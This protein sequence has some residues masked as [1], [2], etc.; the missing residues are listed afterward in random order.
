MGKTPV[1]VCRIEAPCKINLHLGIQE[2]RPDG[3]HDLKSLFVCLALGDTLRFELAGEE[4]S[5]SIDLNW[6]IPGETIPLEKNLVFQAVSLFR[7]R[8]GFSRGLWIRVD[9]RIPPGAGLGGG[10]SDAASALLALNLLSGADIQAEELREMAALLGSDTP[11]F[12]SGGAAY[13]SGRGERIE[14]LKVPEGPWVL[15]VKPP[16]ASDTAF[17]YRLL[18]EARARTR[19]GKRPPDLSRE[20][21][22]RALGEKPD[23]WPFYNDFLPVFLD[24]FSW[25]TGEARARAG[26]YRSILE[27]L[28]A[29]GA[30]F[31]GLSGSGSCC[32]GIFTTKGRVEEAK[33]AFFTGQNYARLT[34]FLAHRA[35][36]VLE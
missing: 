8:T 5:C 3:F 29:Q 30:S 36:A 18:D 9:K 15:L 19:G 16:F 10:S 35:N 21:L 12:L 11:F 1:K 20:V 22:I 31:A 13:V 7:E 32:F 24:T 4:G 25:G 23:V 6:E 17:A 2:K 33:K 26:A 34:F 27:E 14:P 28:R